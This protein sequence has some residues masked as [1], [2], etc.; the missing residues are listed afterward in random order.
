M[1]AIE[2]SVRLLT[3][4]M[5]RTAH[6]GLW[7]HEWRGDTYGKQLLEHHLR[8]N[9]PCTYQNYHCRQ[10]AI[11]DR[12]RGMKLFRVEIN[13]YRQMRRQLPRMELPHSPVGEGWGG[14]ANVPIVNDES[15]NFFCVG[16][17]Y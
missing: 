5:H 4:K 2:L 12:L 7:L 14:G 9:R 6:Q 3:I 10:Y 13:R 15:G 11:R 16:K 1:D 17:P 8:R